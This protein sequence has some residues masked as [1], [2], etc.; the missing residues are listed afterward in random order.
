MEIPGTETYPDPPRNGEERIP[1]RSCAERSFRRLGTCK[2]LH[3][4]ETIST[5]GKLGGVQRVAYFGLGK[6]CAKKKH[7]L[8]QQDVEKENPPKQK[9]GNG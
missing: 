5:G 6:H 9:N 2:Q 4:T 8:S 3:D 1:L 7:T